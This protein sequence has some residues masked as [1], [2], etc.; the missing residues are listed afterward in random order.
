MVTLRRLLAVI[1]ALC[2]LIDGA[3]LGANDY[4]DAWSM[5]LSPI[6]SPLV[7]ETRS[8]FRTRILYA[9]A[10]GTIQPE[11]GIETYGSGISLYGQGIN[12]IPA[13]IRAGVLE[14]QRRSEETLREYRNYLTRQTY[15]TYQSAFSGD[16]WAAPLQSKTGV[17]GSILLRNTGRIKKEYTLS[18]F[19]KG[20][21]FE[22]DSATTVDLSGQLVGRYVIHPRFVLHL[23]GKAHCKQTRKS[24][25][26][27]SEHADNRQRKITEFGASIGV[28]SPLTSSIVKGVHAGFA[29][30]AD[31]ELPHRSINSDMTIVAI[32]RTFWTEAYIARAFRSGAF[33]AYAGIDVM[34]SSPYHSASEAERVSLRGTL[35]LPSLI[36]LEIA[37]WLMLF[38]G[39]RLDGDVSLAEGAGHEKSW[40]PEM[41]LTSAFVNFHATPLAVQVTVAKTLRIMLVPIFSGDGLSSANGEIRATF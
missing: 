22:Y 30:A 34:I 9:T 17:S 13:G 25:M 38:S 8:H 3:P 32:K 4:I 31:H 12:D 26:F 33:S 19:S 35:S 36:R 6:L 2:G 10:C 20:E 37:P 14:Y 1:V 23:G 16:F 21:E 5:L 18:G 27:N 39:G 41:E 15:S 7:P 24:L 11:A 28:C 29:F 40:K